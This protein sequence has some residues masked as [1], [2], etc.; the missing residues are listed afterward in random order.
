MKTPPLVAAAGGACTESVAV[1]VTVGSA[2][3]VATTWIPPNVPS[4]AVYS[5]ELVIDP[6]IDPS[7]IDHVTAVLVVP[8]TVETKESDAPWITTAYGGEMVMHRD[9]A[10][11][12][13]M[14]TVA[15]ASTLGSATLVAITWNVP[16]VLGAVYTPELAMVPPDVPSGTDHVTA[17]FV[18]PFTVA[19]KE[20][21]PSCGT[22]LVA[23]EM[24]REIGDEEGEGEGEEGEK[25]W[26]DGITRFPQAVNRDMPSKSDSGADAG[27]KYFRSDELMASSP[28]DEMS[29]WRLPPDT[30]QVEWPLY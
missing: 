30:P 8:V 10:A 6:P 4:G 3:L 22:E 12:G 5:P 17:E 11:H 24:A 29:A 14:V 20:S 23:G 16:T 15:S 7:R 26:T 27:L 1:A 19:T 18:V 28:Y 9:G 21:D 25:D 2:T 13:A